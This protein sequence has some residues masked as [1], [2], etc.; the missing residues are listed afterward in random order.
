[1]T[2]LKADI[3]EYISEQIE[4]HRKRLIEL[5]DRFGFLHPKVMKASQQ[6]D[7]LLLRYYELDRKK[8]QHG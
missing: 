4:L 6:L 2:I 3:K 5:A 7:V 8:L 1:M